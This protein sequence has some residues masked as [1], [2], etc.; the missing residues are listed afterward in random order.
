MSDLAGVT[1]GFLVPLSLDPSIMITSAG[2]RNPLRD[3]SRNVTIVTDNWNGVTSASVTA[4]WLNEGSEAAD[5]SPTLAQPTIPVYKADAFV[6]FSFEIGQDVVNFVDELGKLLN[7]GYQQLT[8]TAYTTGS[9]V[10]QPT[11]VVT[12]LAGTTQQVNTATGGVLVAGDLY[13][14]QNQ[15]PPRFQANAQFC[16]S[17]PVWNV[18]RQFQ[19][20]NGSLV[21]PSLQNDPP[22]LLGRN[23]NELS[24]MSNTVS[25]GQKIVLYGDFQQFVI[26]DRY[27][28]SVELIQN[29][30][31]ANRRPTGQRGVFLWARTGSGVV[32]PNAFRL[33]SA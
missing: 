27:P 3:I 8:N 18:G 5:A 28:T 33:L 24:N 29:L 22:T 17:L 6:P 7:D 15:L 23:A 30:F 19:T 1:G 14:L 10:N 21:F 20:T 9:G 13:N 4:E 31:G 12:Q 16:A 26:V 25:S 32:V 11:G 2:S